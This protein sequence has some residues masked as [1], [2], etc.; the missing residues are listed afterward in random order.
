MKIKHAFIF[1][2]SHEITIPFANMNKLVAIFHKITTVL[3]CAIILYGTS[4][5]INSLTAIATAIIIA[6]VMYILFYYI[7]AM[8]GNVI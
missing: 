4:I 2:D 5:T 7:A 1:E 6:I 8:L 3:Y